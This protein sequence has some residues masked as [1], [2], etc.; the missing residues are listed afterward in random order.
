MVRELNGHRLNSRQLAFA[1]GVADG[2]NQ[3]DSY[4]SAYPK[5][6][7]ESAKANASRLMERAEVASYVGELRDKTA[8][9]QTLT[10]QRK[11][12][13]LARIVGDE[14]APWGARLRAIDLDNRMGG[15]YEHEAVEYEFKV[16]IGVE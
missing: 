9:A 16:V 7:P 15:D 8:T 3:V 14:S 12:E 11:R 13:I 2:S 6:S 4:R 10:R 1:Q 5:S